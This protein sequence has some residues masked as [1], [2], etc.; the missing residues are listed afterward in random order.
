MKIK[1]FLDDVRKEPVGWVRAHTA[2]DAIE[3]LQEREVSHISL[4]HD[5]GSEEAGTGYDVLKWIEREVAMAGYEPPHMTI[6]SANPVGRK[7]ME[8]AIQSILRLYEVAN[9]EYQEDGYSGPGED[10]WD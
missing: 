2:Q 4:D 8:M 5:L 10:N 1:V 7:R 6:H 3:W 9:M